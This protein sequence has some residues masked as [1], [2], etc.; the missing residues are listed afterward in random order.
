VGVHASHELVAQ[1]IIQPLNKCLVDLKLD[2]IKVLAHSALF[3]QERTAPSANAAASH[4]G[5]KAS[6]PSNSVL[7]FAPRNNPE[8]VVRQRPL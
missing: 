4:A 2:D 1:A 7:L 8:R 6:C 5:V 3:R